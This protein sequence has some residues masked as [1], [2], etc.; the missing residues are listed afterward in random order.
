VTVGPAGLV[1]GNGNTCVRFTD[2]SVRCWGYNGD[3]ELGAAGGPTP[4]LVPLPMGATQISASNR[5]ACA[6]LSDTSLWCWGEPSGLSDTPPA[7]WAGLTGV[8]SVSLSFDVGGCALFT[9]GGVSCWG[10]NETGQLGLGT[11]A[12]SSATIS[13]PMTVPGITNATQISH[14]GATVCAL[15][16]T[17]NMV[18]W[19]SNYYGQIGNGTADSNLTV[20]PNPEP[21][22]TTVPNISGAVQVGT[23]G[24]VSYALLGGANAGALMSWGDGPFA[25]QGD[26][27]GLILTPGRV[28]GSTQFSSICAQYSSCALTVGG[29]VMCWGSDPYGETGAPPTSGTSTF[30]YDPV[31]V[32]SLTNVTGI[33]C[34][35]DFACA[36]TNGNLS[37]MCWGHNDFGQL[38]H[39]SPDAG[40][41]I[42]SAVTW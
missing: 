35:T 6:V 15:L 25:G 33:A 39:G 12:A 18:C 23:S 38:G 13:P 19:G 11:V 31:T 26:V 8:K 42:P 10:R 24:Q 37:V 4:V 36:V 21:S 29:T 27:S 41:N 30:S 17:G 2:G 28:G 3:G 9:S 7:P 22:P 20:T 14:S 16:A 34:G 40:S 1:A 32:P 5:E